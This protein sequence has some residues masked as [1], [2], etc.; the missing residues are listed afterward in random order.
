M[1]AKKQGQSI[2]VDLSHLPKGIQDAVGAELAASIV[3]NMKLGA[4]PLIIGKL[5]PGWW[6]FIN[7]DFKLDQ[8]IKNL[9]KGIG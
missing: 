1:A 2:A 5:G 6:G 8:Q 4:K 3:K 7:P 9:T